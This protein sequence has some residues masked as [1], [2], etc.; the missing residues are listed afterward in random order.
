MLAGIP[1]HRRSSGVAHGFGI[2][3]KSKMS[4]VPGIAIGKEMPVQSSS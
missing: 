4:N 1:H 2:Q 3:S